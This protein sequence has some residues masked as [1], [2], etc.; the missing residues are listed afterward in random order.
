MTI[1]KKKLTGTNKADLKRKLDA[2]K[3]DPKVRID[4]LTELSD[5]QVLISY[6]YNLSK[7]KQEMISTEPESEPKP[8]AS[9]VIP[10]KQPNIPIIG[11]FVFGKETY[12]DE[13]KISDTVLRHVSG[14]LLG[15]SVDRGKVL[16]IIYAEGRGYL[17]IPANTLVNV[18]GLDD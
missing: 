15:Y 17:A 6:E 4:S 14:T 2:F 12:Q 13:G 18:G 5:T 11:S 16:A 10:T 3:A 9:Q 7:V 8:T 1:S